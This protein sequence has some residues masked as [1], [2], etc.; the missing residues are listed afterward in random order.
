MAARPADYPDRL[1]LHLSGASARG[2][3]ASES[4]SSRSPH[5]LV[6]TIPLLI[7]WFVEP[8]KA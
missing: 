8:R 7:V 6:E 5:D 1:V 4:S 3:S 2:S